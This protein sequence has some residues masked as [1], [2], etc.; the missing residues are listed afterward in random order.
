MFINLMKLVL[1]DWCMAA[2][3]SPL[4][5]ILHRSPK[6]KE[7]TVKLEMED[8]ETCEDAESVA[9]TLMRAQSIRAYPRVE[10][11]KIGALVQ[12]LL[13]IFTPDGKIC[14]SKDDLR[15]GALVQALLPIFTPDGKISIEE[16]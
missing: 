15:I 6:L 13:P 3:F 9:L 5:R 12:A 14:C 4:F 8:C 11:I 16:Y 10:R 1:G 7:L 2:D